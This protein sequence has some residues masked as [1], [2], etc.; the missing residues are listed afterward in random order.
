MSNDCQE[1]SNRL[2]DLLTGDV[3]PRDEARLRAHLEGCSSCTSELQEL[4]AGW[5]RL[6][7]VIDVDPPVALRERVLTHAGTAIDRPSS[8]LAEMKDSMRELAA[9]VLAG[10]AG[11]LALITLAYFRGALARLS[12]PLVVALSLALATGLALAVGGFLRARM[13]PATRAVLTGSLAALGGYVLLTA[14]LPISDTVHFCGLVLFGSLRLSLGQLCLTYLSVAALYS[15]I[16]MAIAAYVWGGP[17]D[18]NR[19][20]LAEGLVFTILAAPLVLLQSG[21]EPWVVPLGAVLGFGIGAVAGRFAGRWTHSWV[22]GGA[23][24]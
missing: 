11:A 10:A 3:E 12:Q 1:L 8:I 23:G 18:G 2:L 17:S 15:G 7:G 9:P 22:L 4:R 5:D 24:G 21:F 19:V 20:G 13:R 16:P 6:P 14:A